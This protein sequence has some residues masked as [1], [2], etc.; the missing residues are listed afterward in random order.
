M[1]LSK[2][3][4][5]II[6]IVAAGFVY[7]FF[8]SPA[9]ANIQKIQETQTEYSQMLQ[10]IDDLQKRL[11]SLQTKIDSFPE[12]QRDRLKEML[13]LSINNVEFILELS[14]RAKMNDIEMHGLSIAKKESGSE[15][16]PGAETMVVRFSTESDYATLLGFIKNI[17]KSLR[18]LDIEKVGLNE[19]S[20]FS[21]GVP[22]SSGEYS[23]SITL[24]TY[25]LNYKK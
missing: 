20:S 1:N 10:K 2:T 12:K 15:E 25:W 6:L 17:E 5:P 14:K 4:F 8:I 7:Y 11:H 21:G 22:T 9:Y 13:P 19:T 16:K 18:L 23:Y 24:S 3:I